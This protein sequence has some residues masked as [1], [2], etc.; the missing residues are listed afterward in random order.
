MFQKEF[1]QQL[2]NKKDIDKAIEILKEK[3]LENLT[4][5]TPGTY[6]DDYEIYE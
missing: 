1:I 4:S 2:L 3:R 5:F 6:I